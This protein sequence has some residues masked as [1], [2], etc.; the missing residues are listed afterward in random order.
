[1]AVLVGIYLLDSEAFEV[2]R[3][4]YLAWIGR[5]TLYRSPTHDRRQ[6]IVLATGKTDDGFGASEAAVATAQEQGTAFA[7]ELQADA[8]LEPMAWPE[9]PQS[10]GLSPSWSLRH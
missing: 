8:C 6:W 5:W 9:A 4:G 7:R 2:E 10:A 1:M 3:D